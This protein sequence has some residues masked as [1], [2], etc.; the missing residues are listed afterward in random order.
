M[1]SYAKRLIK[2]EKIKSILK[3]K[4]RVLMMMLKSKIKKRNMSCK[5]Q[6]K[7]ILKFPVFM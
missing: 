1:R 2:I 3:S 7:G 6:P 5:G 4:N